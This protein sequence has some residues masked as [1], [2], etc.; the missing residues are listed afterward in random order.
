MRAQQV[1]TDVMPLTWEIPAAIALSWL[2]LGVI[3]LPAGQALA[4]LLAGHAAV[5]PD[6]DLFGSVWLL[7]HGQP[8]AGLSL[9]GRGTMPPAALVY[10]AIAATEFLTAGCA[11]GAFTMW[12]RH[13]GPG[14]QWGLGR[15]YDIEPVLGAGNLRRRRHLIRPDLHGSGRRR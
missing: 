3:A 5:W 11:M 2:L 14:T 9:A 10:T 15:R 7:L 1:R 13:G 4:F 12:W 6:R 8:G